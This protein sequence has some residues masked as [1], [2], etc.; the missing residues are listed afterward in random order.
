MADDDVGIQSTSAPTARA[1]AV[2]DAASAISPVADCTSENATSHVDGVTAS[3]SR[4]SG[5]WR[6]SRSPCAR[7]GAT[8]ELKSPS[9]TTM[10][11]PAGAD[12]AARATNTDAWDP[13]ATRSVALPSS[14]AACPRARSTTAVYSAAVLLP[15]R[16]RSRSRVRA[17][18]VA[19]A[20][21]PRVQAAR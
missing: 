20:G 10:R 15:V 9:T 2:T 12:A 21:M 5:T 13:T 11:A 18:T 6:T 8:T 4:S 14:D 19:D 17:S 7:N 1:A 3:A 16:Q